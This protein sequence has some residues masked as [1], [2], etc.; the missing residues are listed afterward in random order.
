MVGQPSEEM[1]LRPIYS[2]VFGLGIGLTG[3]SIFGLFAI[4]THTQLW[5]IYGGVGIATLL[6]G[7]R[8]ML[9]K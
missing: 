9:R 1:K 4:H 3:A 7:L 2:A 5:L 8:G 6:F